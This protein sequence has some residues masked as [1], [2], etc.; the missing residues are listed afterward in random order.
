MVSRLVVFSS[1]NQERG[2]DTGSLGPPTTDARSP[3]VNGVNQRCDVLMQCAEQFAL[4][5]DNRLGED[6]P[7]LITDRETSS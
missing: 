7:F 6:L 1:R 3:R 2:L 5:L 4:I